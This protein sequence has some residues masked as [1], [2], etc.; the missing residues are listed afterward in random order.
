MLAQ[1]VVDLL[2]ELLQ[3]GVEVD[4]RV[5]GGLL[6]QLGLLG[7]V[8]VLELLGAILGGDGVPGRVLAEFQ[9]LL[10]EELDAEGVRQEVGD[11]LGLAQLAAYERDL[12]GGLKSRDQ[13]GK[14]HLLSGRR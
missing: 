12:L 9:R 10:R 1:V 8:D 13:E 5:L 4:R 11:D 2:V 6:A 3:R 14:G 7:G